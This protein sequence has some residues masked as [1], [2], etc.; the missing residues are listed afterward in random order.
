[1]STLPL[2]E[3]SEERLSVI[4]QFCILTYQVSEMRA[5]HFRGIIYTLGFVCLVLLLS[6]G[7]VAWRANATVQER[8]MLAEA[9]NAE[10]AARVEATLAAK[11]VE[12]GVAADVLDTRVRRDI[13]D[14]RMVQ[15]ERRSAE[16]EQ[17]AEQVE[18]EKLV[19]AD[20]VT[21]KSIFSAAGL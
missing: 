8:D 21:P 11:D 5:R 16:L 2:A 6:L 18:R 10:R 15:Q 3:P 9:L 14:E 4:D 13:V 19:K 7:V 12:R 17:L 1:M 20:C